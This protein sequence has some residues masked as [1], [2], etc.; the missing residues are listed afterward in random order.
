[1]FRR[2]GR[3]M[4]LRSWLL[5][6]AILGGGASLVV[7]AIAGWWSWQEQKD[8]IGGSLMATGRAISEAVDREVDQA[9][10]LAR[11]LSISTLLAHDDFADF[12]RQA[13][14]AISVYGYNLVLI[15]PNSEF[16]L[17]NTQLPLGA[18]PS[19]IPSS[20]IDPV[21]RQG[22][23]HVG[24]LLHS[25]LSDAWLTAVEVPVLSADRQLRFVITILVPSTV[26]Q[27]IID[28]QRLPTSWSPVILDGDWTVVARDV[29][30]PKFVGQKGGAQE[31]QHAPDGLHE[32]RLLDGD[33]ALSAHSHSRRHG[34][35]TAIA[36][37]IWAMLG[38]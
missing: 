16:Q 8:R 1:M 7:A 33:R 29:S 34:W 18:E 21:L 14:Q 36:M 26:F 17:V 28:E 31:F 24:P 27:R 19:K 4:S 38:E 20:P 32:V 6:L 15:S 12:E 22:R 35:T 9:A 13:R 2:T 11:G 3:S 37:P 10:A 5:C 23:V 25:G 30:R